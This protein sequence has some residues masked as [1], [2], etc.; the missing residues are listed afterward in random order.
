[1]KTVLV[2]GGAGFL[3]SY[4]V[5]E[6]IN[7]DCEVMVVDDLSSCWLDDSGE[8]PRFLPDDPKV[9]MVDEWGGYEDLDAVINVGCRYPLERDRSVITKS[10][11][12]MTAFI[13]TVS[14]AMDCTS[15]KRFVI[16]STLGV[17]ENSGV[18][19]D[20]YISI[21]KAAHQYLSYWHRPPIS[22]ISF[23]HLPEL[24]GPR[25][26]PD[27]SPVLDVRIEASEPPFQMVGYVRE[28]ALVMVDVALGKPRKKVDVYVT[29]PTISDI[30]YTPPSGDFHLKTHGGVAAAKA[31][32]WYQSEGEAE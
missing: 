24:V 13:R 17:F 7:R 16:G 29:T 32:K 10:W 2:I 26:L 23:V 28:A 27:V 1:M 8:K 19:K 18:K 9:K 6:L 14:T 25:Q 5:E 3:G 15:C 20:P 21:I 11:N 22:S 12:D 30:D 31:L 4:I